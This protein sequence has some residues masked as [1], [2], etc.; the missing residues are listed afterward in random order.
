MAPLAN[1][2]AVFGCGG[3]IGGNIIGGIEIG[4]VTT[5]GRAAITGLTITPGGTAEIGA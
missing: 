4:G 1:C 2:V 5:G 3:R